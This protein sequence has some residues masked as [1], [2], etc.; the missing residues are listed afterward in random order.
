MRPGWEETIWSIKFMALGLVSEGFLIDPPECLPL[1]LHGLLWEFSNSQATQG[2]SDLSDI[3]G[4]Y[5]P[6]G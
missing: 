4:Y 5:P 1:S 6:L 2:G 3:L